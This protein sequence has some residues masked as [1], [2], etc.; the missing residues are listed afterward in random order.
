MGPQT[1]QRSQTEQDR[2]TELKGYKSYLIVVA[3]GA[4]REMAHRNYR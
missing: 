2:I 4:E 1:E 3:D